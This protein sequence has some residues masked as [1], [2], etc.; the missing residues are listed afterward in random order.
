MILVRFMFLFLI[1][2]HYIWYNQRI[3]TMIKKSILLAFFF[4]TS[5][6][7]SK[8]QVTSV[9]YPS[10]VLNEEKIT[11]MLENSRKTGTQ[12]WEIQ[13]L[14]RLL[15][16]Q[17][18]EQNIL[19]ANGNLGQKIIQPQPHITAIGCSNAGFENGNT[20]NW[21]LA[22]GNINGVNLPC[23]GCTINVGTAINS[24][25]TTSSTVSG[26]CTN[27]VD[28]CCHLPVVAPAP[29]GGNYS[30]LLNNTTAGGKLQRI[31]QTFVV[32]SSNTTY[33]Y[34]FSFVLENPGQDRKS[35]R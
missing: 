34:Q 24:V 2:F 6:C 21:T 26:V 9:S 32:N 16:N 3:Y 25:V 22:S 28:N 15:H 1:G 10:G 29:L 30:L 5:I 4:A 13:K 35:T 31:S 27:G 14:N 19:I 11:L 7:I 23:N 8:A 20:V 17:L 12:E 18:E 33:A